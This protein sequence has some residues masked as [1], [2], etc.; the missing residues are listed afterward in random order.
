MHKSELVVLGNINSGD[1]LVQVLGCKRSQLPIS[2]L[3]VPL[4]A[5]YNDTRIWDPVIEMFHN[6]LANWKRKL[7]SKGG[8]LIFIKSTLSNLSIYYLSVFSIPSKVAKRLKTIQ[9]NFLWVTTITT[10]NFT[11]SAG[12]RSKNLSKRVAWVCLLLLN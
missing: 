6:R 11:L 10:G 4:G 9:C 5:K 1:S 12:T 7:L 2:Y 8:R 3:G